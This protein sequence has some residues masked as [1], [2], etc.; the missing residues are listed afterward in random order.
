MAR[1]TIAQLEERIREL[2]AKLA[3]RPGDS[4]ELEAGGRLELDEDEGGFYIADLEVEDGD[5]WYFGEAD[6]PRIVTWLAEHFP[7]VLEDAGVSVGTD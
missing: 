7:G 5:R 4:L 1:K 3:A 2:E 6:A